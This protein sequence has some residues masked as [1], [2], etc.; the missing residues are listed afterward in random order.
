MAK[1]AVNLEAA[2]GERGQTDTNQLV[3]SES[4]RTAV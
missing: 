1:T 4:E 3:G 2:E